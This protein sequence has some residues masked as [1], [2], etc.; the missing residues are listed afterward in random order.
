[1]LVPER[2]TFRGFSR[3]YS[4]L[5]RSMSRS[6]FRHCLTM[7]GKAQSP[8]RWQNICISIIILEDTFRLST[9]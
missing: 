5:E 4:L 1:M 8:C 7:D 3:G 2:D 9:I 6:S